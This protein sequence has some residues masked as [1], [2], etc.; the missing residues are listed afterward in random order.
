LNQAELMAARLNAIK[1]ARFYDGKA[2][3]CA[4]MAR[5]AELQRS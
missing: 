1:T 3:T 4:L 2:C 5:F